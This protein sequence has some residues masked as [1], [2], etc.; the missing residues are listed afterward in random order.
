M[1]HGVRM[2]SFWFHV[3]NVLKAKFELSLQDFISRKMFSAYTVWKLRKFSLM[4]FWQKFRESNSST[5]QVT[6]ELIWR[7][8][9][10]V[11]VNLSYFHTVHYCRKSYLHI[12]S[13]ISRKNLKDWFFVI[14]SYKIRQID[15][16]IFPN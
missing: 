11:R 9:F 13:L 6:K 3:K 7:K 15:C 14:E 8:H 10:L 2:K 16:T 1:N 4:Y 5:K 12:F